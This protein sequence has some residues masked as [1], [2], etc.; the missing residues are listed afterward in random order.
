MNEKDMCHLMIDM[1]TYGV[2]SNAVFRS[3]AGVLFN[4]EGK[5]KELFNYGIDL[6]DSLMHGLVIDQE[7]INFWR[8]ES[9]K[10][11]KNLMLLPKNPL[12]EILWSIKNLIR[13][14]VKDY[15]LIYMWS[16]GSSFD[17]VLLENAYKAMG[18]KAWW[19]Y[20]KVRDTRTLFDVANYKYKAKG[21][22]DALEDTKNQVVAVC[23]AYQLIKEGK[24]NGNH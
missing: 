3:I 6:E 10:N 17:I 9:E 4:L 21:G 14:E 12:N 7:T 19:K 2:S 5:N 18:E 1:E 8:N 24:I 16:H 13:Q 22:H 23:E 11:R 15:S 20:S